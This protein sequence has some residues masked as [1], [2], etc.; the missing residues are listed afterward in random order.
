[1]TGA[2]DLSLQERYAP[3]GHCFGCGP[4]NPEGLRIRSF[5]SSSDPDEVVADW[6]P[7]P[8]HE[9]FDGVLNGGIIGALLDCHSNWT[10]S[11]HLMR[12]R[13]A[14]RPPTTVTLDYAVRFR[15]PT[16]SNGQVHLSAR[17]VESSDDR[18]TVEARLSAGDEVTATC[19]GTFV[20]VKRDHPAY[21]RW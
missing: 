17:V 15:R 5:P 9:A 6:T 2:T 16:P 12:R 14:D 20:A 13:G 18:A 7:Q 8:H 11:S 3:R 4:A 21:D 19:R 1:M 10:A